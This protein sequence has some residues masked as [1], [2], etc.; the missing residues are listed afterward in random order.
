MN[1]A[2]RL[3]DNALAN[4][5]VEDPPT[6]EELSASAIE[7]VK[8]LSSVINYIITDAFNLEQEES[9]WVGYHLSEIL[10][11]LKSITPTA[12]LAA[13]DKELTSKEYTQRMV[14]RSS[15][16]VLIPDEESGF[17]SGVK[18]APV[19][20]WVE[21]IS[22]IILS[23]YPDLRPMISSSIIGSIHGLFTEL[24]ISDNPRTSRASLYLPNSVRYL[25]GNNN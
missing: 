11:P 1:D 10:S 25:L 19:S 3:L 15:K 6:A 20:D 14:R 23:S 4:A 8:A 16:I 9:L 18:Y 5:T 24:G 13:V 21:G 17:S 7:T 22:E 2:I 12:L